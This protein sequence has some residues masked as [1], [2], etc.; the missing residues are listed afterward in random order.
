M[1]KI[2]EVSIDGFWQDFT[3]STTFGGDVNIIIGKNGTG[4]TTFMN[5][6][7]A[8]LNVD[9]IALEEN[10]F[11]QVVIKLRKGKHTKTVKVKKELQE[12]FFSI[13]YNVSRNS[14]AFPLVFGE[15]V[16]YGSM[17]RR[18]AL[19][20]ISGV[21]EAL[22]EIVCVASLSVYRLR[23]SLDV[24]LKERKR[25]LGPVDLHL[26]SLMRGLT[27]YQLE[28]SQASRNISVGLQKEVLTSLLYRREEKVRNVF[29]SDFDEDRQRKDLISVYKNLGILD[30]EVNKRI[31]E[32]LGLVKE[33]VSL[34]R[35][36]PPDWNSID[37]EALDAAERVH[38]V[39]NM[40]L[41]A[42]KKTKELYS[43]AN[44]FLQLLSKFI[45]GKDFRIDSSGKLAI[46]RVNVLESGSD[47]RI[48]VERLSSGE[49]QL[50]ILFV[51]ALLQRQKPYVFLADEPELSLHIEWQ[52]NI[53]PAIRELNPN[54]QIIVATHSPEVAG[55]YKKDIIN[56]GA[57]LRVSA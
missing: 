28:L 50:I 48:P 49:K 55:K 3:A 54:A 17:A 22:S 34:Y 33:A 32:H 21:Q 57:I 25:I 30:S 43:H 36:D 6:L 23:A 44:S 46:Y 8:V 2:A 56:M 27:E 47:A 14:Y 39:F 13:H 1:Y 7:S 12:N 41:K 15:E 24:D 38:N 31:N 18:R 37:L 26:E 16:R 53:I 29:A 19:D 45:V 35:V 52:R 5:V 20:L 4:K 10:E 51:E 42:E 40:S 9:P 11:K